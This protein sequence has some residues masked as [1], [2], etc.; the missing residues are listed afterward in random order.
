MVHEIL[1]AL[2]SRFTIFWNLTPC[3]L[4]DT[5]QCFGVDTYQSFGG[6]C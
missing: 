2:S 6:T 4:V 3:S 1:M 5:Y